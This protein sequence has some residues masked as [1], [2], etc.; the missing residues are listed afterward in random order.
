MT[1][2]RKIISLF[3]PEITNLR[4]RRCRDRMVAGFTIT[5]AIRAYHYSRVFE[6]R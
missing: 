5:Y 1:P 4:G 3:F 2:Y 6:S